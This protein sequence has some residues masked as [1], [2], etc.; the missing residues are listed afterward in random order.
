MMKRLSK[1][2]GGFT[3]VET[4]TAMM[5]LA[6]SLTVILQIFSGGLRAS[7][8]SNDYT[9]AVFHAREKMEE[10]LLLDRMRDEE[11]QGRF[12]DGYRW[13]ARIVRMKT[14]ESSGQPSDLPMGL[15]GVVVTVF[16][17]E[18]EQGKLFEINTLHL[19]KEIDFDRTG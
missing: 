10:L 9:R 1:G 8:V 7:R 17:N 16:W 3:L 19:A 4:L 6:I 15:F 12:S 2:G 13:T 18:A 11:L 14:Q 5:I